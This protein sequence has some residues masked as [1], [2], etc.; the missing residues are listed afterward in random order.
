[1]IRLTSDIWVSAYLG[2]FGQAQPL[3]R[4]GRRFS[5]FF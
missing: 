5:A 1:M 3:G 2:G 4:A